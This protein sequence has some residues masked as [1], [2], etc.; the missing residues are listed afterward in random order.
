MCHG[1]KI[2]IITPSFNQGAYIEDT[3]KSVLLQNYPNLE[4]IVID[5]GSSDESVDIIRK[6]DSQLTYWHSC[7]DK[8]QAHAINQ[9]FKMATGEILA[10]LNADDMYMP[11]TLKRIADEFDKFPNTDL[12]YGDCVFI[13]EQGNFIR[14]FTECEDYDA[15]RLLNF[16][17]FIMQPT[18][19]FSKKKLTEVGFLDESFFYAMDYELWCRFSKN[20]AKFKFMQRVLAANRVYSETKTS[21]GGIKRLREIYRLQKRYMTGF[22]PHAFWGFTATEVYNQGLSSGNRLIK[23]ILKFLGSFI[24]LLSP[25]AVFYSCKN[26]VRKKV[27]YGLYPHSSSCSGKVSIYLPFYNNDIYSNIKL[28]LGIDG[29]IPSGNQIILAKVRLDGD[30]YIEILLTSK[31]KRKKVTLSINKLNRKKNMILVELNF[32]NIDPKVHGHLYDIK[33]IST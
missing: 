29:R 14:Y 2:S 3:I 24:S 19:F 13:D 23:Y 1:K 16:S 6:Y 4:Y 5:G 28:E 30:D 17:N 33:F 32:V 27:R 31:Y 7:P 9:G 26:Q 10:W 25:H 22:W 11:G 15:H 12:I 21:S 20:N 18:T 8:G